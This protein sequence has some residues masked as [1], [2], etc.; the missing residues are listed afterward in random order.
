MNLGT[1]IISAY[2]TF[3]LKKLQKFYI[4]IINYRLKVR[5]CF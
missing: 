2:K 3:L 5:A 4:V 1:A